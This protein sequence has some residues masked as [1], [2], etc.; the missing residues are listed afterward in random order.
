[1]GLEDSLNNKNFD[2]L[3]A[4]RLLSQARHVFF[5]HFEDEESP[6]SIFCALLYQAEARILQRYIEEKT[7]FNGELPPLPDYEFT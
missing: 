7:G 3:P 5:S 6:F 2:F 1:M 4:L